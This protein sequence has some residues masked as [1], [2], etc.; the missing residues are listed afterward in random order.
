MQFLIRKYINIFLLQVY[1]TIYI[2]IYIY[3]FL[4]YFNKQIQ[5][6]TIN[7]DKNRNKN[8]GISVLEYC[9]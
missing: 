7:C 5:M 9:R 2:Q 6:K 1:Y 8:Y 4:Y 3:K